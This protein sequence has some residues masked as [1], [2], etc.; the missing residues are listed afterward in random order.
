MDICYTLIN[1]ALPQGIQFMYESVMGMRTRDQH[2]CI[3]ADEM[4]V[5][6]ILYPLVVRINLRPLYRGLGKTLQVRVPICSAIMA[7]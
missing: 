7:S 6:L 4:F 3:L 2:G 5:D 1:I